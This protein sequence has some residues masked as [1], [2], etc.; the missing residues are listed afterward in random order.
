MFVRRILLVF[1]VFG[2]CISA[3]EDGYASVDPYS[4]GVTLTSHA[5]C[6]VFV[7]NVLA[8][9]PADKAGI[10]PG[11]QMLRIGAKEV[12]SANDAAPKI[13]SEGPG[14]V[15]VRFAHG[16]QMFTT[17]IKREKLSTIYMLAG[18]KIISGF[19]VPRDFFASGGGADAGI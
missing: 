7:L 18:V 19:V 10:R 13:R 6:P 3:I 2:T 12:Q 15:S 9:S 16:G 11:D 5:G 14:S 8:H 4:I 17:V 1:L